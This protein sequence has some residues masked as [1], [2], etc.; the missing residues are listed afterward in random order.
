[1]AVRRRP[2]TSEPTVDPVGDRLH[3]LASHWVIPC[4]D[5]DTP[6]SRA[7]ARAQIAREMAE[8]AGRHLTKDRDSPASLRRIG[9]A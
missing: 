9:L 1:M 6:E 3:Y 4:L 2:A 5:P 8:I 7:R